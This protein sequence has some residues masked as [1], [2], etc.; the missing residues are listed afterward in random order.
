MKKLLLMF[1]TITMITATSG[2]SLFTKEV[3]YQKIANDLNKKN[4]DEIMHAVDG[5]AKYEH[6][7]RV[8]TTTPVDKNRA[9]EETTEKYFKGIYK[10]NNNTALGRWQKSY[11]SETEI[12]NKD[13]YIKDKEKN[14]S[15][16]QTSYKNH[17]YINKQ[18]ND[19]L[20]SQFVFDQLQGIEKL[21]PK[22]YKYGMDEPPTVAYQLNEKEFNN[23]IN[24]NLRV[25]YD[26]LKQAMITINLY[27]EENKL[28]I[29]T[30]FISIE[31]KKKINKDQINYFLEDRL[32]LEDNNKKAKD[33]YK[34]L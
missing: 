33:E 29:K 26:K 18:T 7:V 9:K 17:Q 31:W 23:I 20:D 5:Y 11:K 2:C 6:V 27:R 19:T 28:Y 21:T 15:Y 25:D 32:Y 34:R 3:D 4:M 12:K 8:I 22:S 10:T 24:D 14:S 1:F 16:Y 13:K 30:I